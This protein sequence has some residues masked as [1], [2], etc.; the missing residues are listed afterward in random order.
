MTRISHV[1]HFELATVELWG[2]HCKHSTYRLVLNLWFHVFIRT[3]SCDVFNLNITV[4]WAPRVFPFPAFVAWIWW[5]MSQAFGNPP[6]AKTISVVCFCFTDC[7]TETI[8]LSIPKYYI[9]CIPLMLPQIKINKP[10]QSNG[11]IASI[12][13][14]QQNL[15]DDYSSSFMVCLKMSVSAIA[16]WV[17]TVDLMEFS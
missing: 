15:Y 1:W 7:E 9:L 16:L 3:C 12:Y 13:T 11:I 8:S 6:K 14:I 2:V 17:V 10:L 5:Y 4:V